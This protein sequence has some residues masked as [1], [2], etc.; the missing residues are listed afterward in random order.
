MVIKRRISQHSIDK[1][2]MDSYAMQMSLYMTSKL[3]RQDYLENLS[4][5]LKK[6]IPRHRTNLEQLH[7]FLKVFILCASDS[8]KLD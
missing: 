7:A 5:I 1:D 2:N 3:K 6:G 8:I 4:N